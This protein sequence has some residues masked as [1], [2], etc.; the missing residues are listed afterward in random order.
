[1][2]LERL[3]WAAIISFVVS[4]LLL[5][6]GGYVAKDQLPPYPGT[7][8]DERGKPLFVQADIF[9][10]QNVYQRYGLMDH[11]SVWGHGS[12]RGPEFSAY[13][14]HLVSDSIRNDLAQKDYCKDYAAL[15]SLEKEIIDVK[16]KKEIRTNRYDPKNEVLVLTAPQVQ[17]LDKVTRF[18]EDTFHRGEPHYYADREG[19]I[20]LWNSGAA[21]IFGYGADEA[22]GQSL[23]LIIPEKLRPRHWEGYRR[24]M[25]SGS[26]RY[27]RELLAVP[28]VRKDGARISVEFTMILVRSSDGE[29]MG[30]AAIIRDVTARWQKEQETKVR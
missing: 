19:R 10:G 24:V 3:K 26:T 6:G 1:M 12:Q 29:L 21:L 20:E 15:E 13:T 27:G 2:S 5:I 4:T 8:V 14:L 23:D 7:V 30:S 28:A 17:A 25:A 9:E 22:I 16:L 11:G 18:W